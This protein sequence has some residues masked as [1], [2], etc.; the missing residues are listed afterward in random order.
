MENYHK[1]VS[2][3]AIATNYFQ[4]MS[5]KNTTEEIVQITSGL[6]EK[7]N[8]E[9]LSPFPY[10]N[11]VADHSDLKILKTA[12]PSAISGAIIFDSNLFTIFINQAKL[13][14]TQYFAIAHELGHYFLHKD[15][16]KSEPALV[17]GEQNYINPILYLLEKSEL[18]QIESE[19]NNFATNLIMPTKLV[20]K[21]WEDLHDVIQCAKIFN[22]SASA[23]SLRLEKLQ[24]L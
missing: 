10:E 23:M 24:L 16:L 15:I 8:P 17:D 19:A 1:N 7:Y 22:V 18:T 13:E 4:S 11:I 3:L 2:I 9:N 20:S 14:T 21:A 12:L 5:H 6:L